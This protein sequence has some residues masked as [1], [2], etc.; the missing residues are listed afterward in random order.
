MPEG[1]G[2]E[3]S[4]GLMSLSESSDEEPDLLVLRLRTAGGRRKGG[5]SKKR[6]EDRRQWQEKRRK[7]SGRTY[8]END[9]APKLESRDLKG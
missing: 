8:A 4:Q 6:G 5:S 7:V 3:E 2:A 1:A 9:R